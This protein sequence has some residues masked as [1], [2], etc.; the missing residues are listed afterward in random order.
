[1]FWENGK[2]Y[3]GSNLE[4]M[5]RLNGIIGMADPGDEYY[6]KDEEEYGLG[7]VRP[8]EKFF[9]LYGIHADTKTVEDHLCTFVGKPM[10]RK[11]QPFLRKNGMGI[12]FSKIEFEWKD[13]A[14]KLKGKL[15][16]HPGNRS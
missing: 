12:D 9:K 4:G 14:K 6:H 2:L 16:A 7:Q 5:K 1:M 3:P 11:F 13:P 10:M 15:T 8:K